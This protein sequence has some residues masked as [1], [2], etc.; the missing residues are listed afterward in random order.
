MSVQ[1]SNSPPIRII[2]ASELL[3]FKAPK[4]IVKPWIEAGSR[5][6]I[7]GMWGLGKTFIA[8]DMSLSIATGR[9]WCDNQPPIRKTVQARVCTSVLRARGRSTVA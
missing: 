3:E 1:S 7:Y 2:H 5:N 9:Q 6:M 8:L 4:W